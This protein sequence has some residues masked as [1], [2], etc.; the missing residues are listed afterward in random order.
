L[1]SKV[2][3]D[4]LSTPELDI[5]K[6][7]RIIIAARKAFTMKKI[8]LTLVVVAGLGA[9]GV[10]LFAWSGF[11][12]VAATKGHFAFVSWFLDFGMRNSVEFH[13]WGIRAPQLDDEALFE[14]GIGHFHGGCAPCH[15]APGV[16]ASPIAQQMLPSA[17]ELSKVVGRWQPNQLFWI[18]RHGLK[19][20]GMPAWTAPTRED[21]VWAVVAFLVRLPQISAE[22]YRR[23]AMVEELEAVDPARLI[24]TAGWIEGDPIACARCHGIQ[25]SGS[26][27]GGVPKLAGQK[28]AYLAMTLRD[29]EFGL[30]PS[31]IMHPVAIYLTDPER[32]KLAHYYA[33]IETPEAK[34][35]PV[36]AALEDISLLQR[37]GALASVGAPRRGIPACSACHG[38][39][40]R[41]EGMNPRFPALAGQHF[42]YL[43]YQLELWRAGTRGGTFNELMSRAARNLTD[44]EIVA[45]AAYYSKLGESGDGPRKD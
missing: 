39:N 23:L 2:F 14:R 4:A 15:G 28:P 21:E 37:G 11:Y 34:A 19:Y 5:S 13:A 7:A 35:K 43:A 44:Q 9:A 38:E 22:T 12:S 33:S 8:L 45:L 18:V 32:E 24:S 26:P 36:A 17:P 42:D 6:P 27:A 41:A 29:Y 30:R 31:G 1:R 25:G 16:P 10:L 3:P 40:G 20:T